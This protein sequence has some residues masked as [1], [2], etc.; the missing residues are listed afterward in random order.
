MTARPKSN[1]VRDKAYRLAVAA[2]P[3]ICCG[4]EGQSQCAHGPT[5]GR[6]IKASDMD[7]FPLCCDTPGRLGCHG[8]HDKREIGQ[9]RIDAAT[10]A[11][12]TRLVLAKGTKAA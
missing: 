4:I 11:E 9:R 1:P 3:C 12:R 2:L 8:L 6:G 10:W 5:L 7:T